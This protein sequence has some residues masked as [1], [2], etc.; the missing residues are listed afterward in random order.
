MRSHLKVFFDFEERTEMLTE[1]ERGR[2]LLAMLHY[3]KTGEETELR[4][5]ERYLWPVFKADIDR[6]VRAYEAHVQAG[7]QGGRPGNQD[8]RETK[9]NQTEPNE[10][11]Q[12]Q[13]E[14]KNARQKKEEQEQEEETGASHT[15]KAPPQVMDARAREG[16]YVDPDGEIRPCRYDAAWMTSSRARAAVAQRVI[17]KI[18]PLLDVR[19]AGDLHGY[20]MDAMK[21][22]APPEWIEDAAQL[23]G[24]RVTRLLAMIAVQ[25]GPRER[26]ADNIRPYGKPG[27]ALGPSAEGRAEEEETRCGFPTRKQSSSI[28]K[29]RG[30]SAEGRA[31]NRLC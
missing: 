29:W 17:E 19:A 20:L 6:D 26:R 12:N 5:N 10:T 31:E 16:G 13:T 24:G 25:Y 23:A 22:G 9:Q 2:L 3:A 21:S 1:A 18:T 4:G 11:K 8:E 27:V 15:E 28:E 14:P 30:P 7:K